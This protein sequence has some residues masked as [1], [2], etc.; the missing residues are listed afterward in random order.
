MVRITLISFLHTKS[1]LQKKHFFVFSF[2]ASVLPFNFHSRGYFIL[3]KQPYKEKSIKN[4]F[5]YK[6]TSFIFLFHSFAIYV[7]WH[8][9]MLA[10]KFNQ[11]I[12]KH[13]SLRIAPV[14]LSQLPR[15]F[16]FNTDLEKSGAPNRIAGFD[17]MFFIHGVFIGRFI[18]LS[19]QTGTPDNFSQRTNLINYNFKFLQEMMYTYLSKLAEFY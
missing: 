14:F 17:F 2:A 19:V 15:E 18:F 5:F 9:R 8:P 11:Q 10:V 1:I 6:P 12:K 13:F 16:R 3:K 4:I 7:C